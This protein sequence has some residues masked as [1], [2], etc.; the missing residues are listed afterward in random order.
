MRRGHEAFLGEDM[1]L[2]V[3]GL[4][5]TY[6]DNFAVRVEFTMHDVPLAQQKFVQNRK[7]QGRITGTMS[8]FTWSKYLLNIALSQTMTIDVVGII[9][10]PKPNSEGVK[11]S[12]KVEIQDVQ[13]TTADLMN[14][15]VGQPVKFELPFVAANIKEIDI[16]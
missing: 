3:N 5:M 11:N 15:Q 7:G 16:A 12:L 9:T 10:N 13:F 14:A 6:V 8:G 1:Q 2:M 4:T